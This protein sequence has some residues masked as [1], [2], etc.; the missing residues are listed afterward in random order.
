MKFKGTQGKWELSIDNDNIV[1]YKESTSFAI[2]KSSQE[3]ELN[4][5]DYNVNEYKYN[6][7]LISCA[8]ELL[9]MVNK[10]H[11]LLEEHQPNWYLLGHHKEIQNLLEKSTTI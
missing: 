8:P 4:G 3:Q 5:A 9:E 1:V 11:E 7:K 2:I 6:A 10:V